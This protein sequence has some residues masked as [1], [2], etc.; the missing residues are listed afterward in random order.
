M[1]TASHTRFLSA[2]KDELSF[3]SRSQCEEI[4]REVDSHLCD[5]A[6]RGGEAAVEAAIAGYGTP[7]AYAERL[8]EA[9]GLERA[10]AEP[11]TGRLLGATLSYAGRSLVLLSG[12]F[13]SFVFAALAL[14]FLAIAVV[15][16]A[17]PELTGLYVGEGVLAFG[18]VPPSVT[19]GI[20]DPLGLWI[21]PV[22]VA[23][24]LLSAMSTV[25]ILRASLKRR[26]RSIRNPG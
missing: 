25:W 6:A 11:A 8:M 9:Y 21:L 7:R 26:L 23:G 10:L 13:V 1:T 24:A 4:L 17:A 14:A 19:Q 16:L 12:A 20:E 18:I 15:E 22:S 5:M 2:L 3:V